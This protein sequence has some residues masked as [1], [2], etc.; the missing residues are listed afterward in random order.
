M[1]GRGELREGFPEEV[2]FALHSE[3]D[4]QVNGQEWRWRV[5]QR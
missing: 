4:K 5:W 1:W 3:A 2:A